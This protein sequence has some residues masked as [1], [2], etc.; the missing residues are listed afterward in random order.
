MLG[1]PDLKIEEISEWF[2]NFGNLPLLRILLNSLTSVKIREELPV[3]IS[4]FKIISG[5]SFFH[6]FIYE[7]LF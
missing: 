3:F 2:H 1:S 4:S 6:F 7:Y 5:P